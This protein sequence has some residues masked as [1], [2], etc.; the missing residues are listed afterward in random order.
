MID[1]QIDTPM[2]SR[3]S[4]LGKCRRDLASTLKRT[5]QGEPS[6][7]SAM[8]L[9]PIEANPAELHTVEVH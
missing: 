7:G 8:T 1:S 4:R 3:M 2:S 6:P 9:V 5:A